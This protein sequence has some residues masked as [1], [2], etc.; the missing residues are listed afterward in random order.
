MFQIDVLEKG[1]R[2]LLRVP[3]LGTGVA[4]G[5]M[6]VG[7]G[8][9][10]VTVGGTTTGVGVRVGVRVGVGVAVAGT[11]VL[12]RVGVGVTDGTVVAVGNGVTVDVA[13][14]TAVF[15]GVCTV[16]VAVGTT[17]FVAVATVGVAVGTGVLVLVALGVN[18]AIGEIDELLGILTS[19][20]AVDVGVRCEVTS[21]PGSAVAL[22]SLDAL[23]RD[24]PPRR[25][26]T[27]VPGV[28]RS[29]ART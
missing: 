8:G 5:G 27:D 10:G 7:V 24:Q 14:G 19:L 2:Y 28:S 9:T 29:D 20:V 6:G 1:H 11:A 22:A 23:S 26:S 3:A 13:V 17:V 18:V 4:V 25:R 12:V 21:V 16:G 15:V